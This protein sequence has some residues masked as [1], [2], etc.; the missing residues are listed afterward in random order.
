MKYVLVLLLGLVL[1]GALVFFV[2]VGAPRAGALPGAAV[3]PPDQGG[4]PAGTAVVTLDEKFFDSVLA[5]IFRDMNAPSF[6]LQLINM[7]GGTQSPPP[8]DFRT[9]VFQGDCNNVVTLV[10]EGSNVKTS[11]RLADGKIVAPLAF[12]GSYNAPFFGCLRFKGW[13]QASIQLSFD[14]SKQTVYGRINVEGVTLDNAPSGV[15]DVV[16]L[17]VQRTINERV[18]PLEILQSH[19]LMLA[20]PVKSSNSTLK[21]QVKDV[22]E[23]VQNGKLSLHITYDFSAQKQ[24]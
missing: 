18:N 8:V 20:V 13:A 14:Q 1:G 11:V 17:L 10:P 9:A 3:R 23:E 19:Q 24:G 6:P 2:F 7:E 21:A 16:T 5:T 22:R 4:D 12:N 15:G